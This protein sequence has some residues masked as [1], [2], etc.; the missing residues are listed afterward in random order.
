[1]K[2]NKSL[3]DVI[4]GKVQ[5]KVVKQP[6]KKGPC[7]QNEDAVIGLWMSEDGSQIKENRLAKRVPR[8]DTGILK[9]RIAVKLAKLDNSSS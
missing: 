9:N 1:M 4:V 6:P 8:M 7:V 3:F 2:K 5:S